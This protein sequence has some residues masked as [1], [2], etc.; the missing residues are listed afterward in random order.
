MFCWKWLSSSLALAPGRGPLSGPGWQRGER[1]QPGCQLDPLAVAASGPASTRSSTQTLQSRARS[2]R[3][4]TSA[5][6]RP[7]DL[8]WSFKQTCMPLPWQCG[9]PPW[10]TP[11]CTRV[12]HKQVF[13]FF[14][15][16]RSSGFRLPRNPK[17]THD[18]IYLRSVYLAC[19]EKVLYK[20]AF[21]CK[22]GKQHIFFVLLN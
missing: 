13:C 16:G 7:Q 10:K 5:T 8:C 19:H 12:Y 11:G 20:S 22:L 18:L 9:P 1:T 21:D 15:K 4:L 17:Y 14:L 6:N 3:L 2:G